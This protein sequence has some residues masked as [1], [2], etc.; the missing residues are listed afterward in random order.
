MAPSTK[1]S[2]TIGASP[3]AERVNDRPLPTRPVS[4]DLDDPLAGIPL[5]P[6]RAPGTQTPESCFDR[7]HH[8]IIGWPTT[9]DFVSLFDRGGTGVVSAPAP[10]RSRI[11]HRWTRGRTHSTGMSAR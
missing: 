1:N 11:R 8:V 2:S 6:S 10:S 9:D 4:G 5:A 7:G 3:R